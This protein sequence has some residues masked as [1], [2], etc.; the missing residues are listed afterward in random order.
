[1][2]VVFAR[3]LV[4]PQRPCRTGRWVAKC[5]EMHF[6]WQSWDCKIQTYASKENGEPEAKRMQNRIVFNFMILLTCQLVGEV[7]TRLLRL[8]VPGPVLG[9]VILFCGLVVRGYVPDDMGAVTDGLLQNLS[10]LFVPAGVGVMLHARLLADNWLA[11]SVALIASAV[12]TIAVTGLVMTWAARL[13][14]G[15]G[16]KAG[17]E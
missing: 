8:P 14:A 2:A 7:I 3:P 12:S 17:V 10:L 4:P 15:Q 6:L 16:E 11:L 9:M 5:A 1:M 13:T